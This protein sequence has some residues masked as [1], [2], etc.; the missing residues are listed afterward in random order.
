MFLEKNVAYDLENMIFVAYIY[1][2]C[3][4]VMW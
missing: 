4:L 3:V 2:F 1:I